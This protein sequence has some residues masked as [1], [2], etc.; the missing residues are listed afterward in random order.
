MENSEMWNSCP[1]HT[2]ALNDLYCRLCKIFC[3]DESVNQ[4]IRPSCSLEDSTFPQQQQITKGLSISLLF[5][6]TWFCCL[7]IVIRYFTKFRGLTLCSIMNVVLWHEPGIYG[8][9]PPKVRKGIIGIIYLRGP[10]SFSVFPLFVYIDN[11]YGLH[12]I[13]RTEKRQNWK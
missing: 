10:A 11:I 5:Y 9:G 3:F 6:E 8:S 13:E 4:C 12:W 7:M 2:K 1:W